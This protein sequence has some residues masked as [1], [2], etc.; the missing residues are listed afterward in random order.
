MKVIV[1]CKKNSQNVLTIHGS[2]YNFVEMLFELA[3]VF[4][5]D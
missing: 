3:Y 4:Q 5:N 1:S 2:N